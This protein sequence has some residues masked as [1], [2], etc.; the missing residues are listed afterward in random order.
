[1]CSFT[2]LASR[3]LAQVC[4]STFEQ[5][6]CS[7]K[8]LSGA[9]RRAAAKVGDPRPCACE[10]RRFAFSFL[11]RARWHGNQTQTQDCA[12]LRDRVQRT[13]RL[14]ASYR[15]LMSQYAALRISTPSSHSSG[16]CR[17][18]LELHRDQHRTRKV[19]PL[20]SCGNRVGVAVHHAENRIR[21]IRII[22]QLVLC[23]KQAKSIR[24]C[25]VNPHSN[26]HEQA[27]RSCLVCPKRR[28][29][30]DLALAVGPSDCPAPYRLSTPR[31]PKILKHI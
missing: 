1:M 8:D 11:P 28:E 16:T 3:K 27:S 20:A 26:V 22:L 18:R 31:N 19:T 4:Q 25:A 15:V 17:P 6:F 21:G 10:Q 9:A 23:T 13:S 2:S 7:S 5:R 12:D 14:S 30:K 24:T 29:Q